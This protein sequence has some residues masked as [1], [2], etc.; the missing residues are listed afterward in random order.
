MNIE[1]FREF[2]LSL[3]ATG[4]KMPFDQETLVFTVMDKMFALTNIEKFESVNLKCDPEEAIRLREMYSSIV[5]GWHMN[6]KHWNTILLDGSLDDTQLL[7]WIKHS[8]DCVVRSLPK[9]VQ[10]ELMKAMEENR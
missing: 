1:S 3:P 10:N 5:P 4:E 9:K 8:Y 6:K 2:C 7:H